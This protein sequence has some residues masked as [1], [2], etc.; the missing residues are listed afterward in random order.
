LLKNL[1]IIP[2]TKGFSLTRFLEIGIVGQFDDLT[3]LQ[4]FC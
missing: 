2:F 3:N 4:V 1:I